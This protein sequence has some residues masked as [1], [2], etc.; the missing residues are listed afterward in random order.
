V[1]APGRHAQQCRQTA[2]AAASLERT[3]KILIASP[4]YDGCV[5]REYMRSVMELTHD[6]EKRNI[7]W[8]LLIEPATLLHTMRNVMASQALLDPDC[9]HLLF[10]DC[11]LEFSTKSIHKLI[12]AQRDVIGCAY[13]Y[14]TIP[15]HLPTP[16][17][18]QPLRRTISALVPYA[19]QFPRGTTQVDVQSGICNVL[20]IGTGLLLIQRTALERLA[21]LS[22]VKRFRT[23]FPYNQWYHADR[24]Y[25]FFNHLEIDG[26]ELGEDYSFC[27]RW[28][29][30]CDGTIQALVDEEV[31]HIGPL[32]VLGCYADRLRSGLL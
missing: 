18:D 28:I 30:D 2:D 10:I 11:D 32:P 8:S 16:T 22:S 27:H 25:G 31:A 3:V 6:F 20:S 1:P 19:L 9:T 24:Y 7:A 23:G 5:R 14:R 12:A 29:H 15:L 21:K 13:P 17:S 4:T 26:Q